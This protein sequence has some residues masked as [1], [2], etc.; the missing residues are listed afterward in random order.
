M[1]LLEGIGTVA[2]ASAGGSTGYL[3]VERE[4]TYTISGCEN[5]KLIVDYGLNSG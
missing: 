5:P 2:Q 1:K 3:H 4:I